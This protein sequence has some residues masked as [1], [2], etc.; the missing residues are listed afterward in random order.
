MDLNLNG[1]NV[2]VSGATRG[3]GAA[4]ST[5]LASAG[6]NVLGCYR[7]DDSAAD[8]LLGTLNDSGGK[9]HLVKADAT[10]P[11]DVDA[12]MDEFRERYDTVHAVVNNAAAISHVPFDQLPADEWHRILDAGLTSSY[13][14]T[15]KALP[16]L[17]EGSSVVNMGSRVAVVGVPE[18]AHYAAA[19][20]G[21]TGLTRT[22]SKE[23]ASRRIRV[24]LIVPGVVRT[25]E[26]E[27]L[28]PERL[29]HYTAMIPLG[30][31]ALPDEVA[32]AVLFLVSDLASY[33]TG[34]TLSVDGGM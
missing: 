12:M 22:L 18:R 17:A 23:L 21:L 5:K 16:L 15:Q 33:I 10:V 14:V 9:H 28:P 29:R 31:L 26:A 1:R 13:L 24:N 19:K 30:R 27:N 20:A 8:A 34:T 4:I 32:N 11:A 3:I 2:I 25:K 7:S 6:A